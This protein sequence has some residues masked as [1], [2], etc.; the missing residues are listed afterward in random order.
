MEHFLVNMGYALKASYLFVML[1]T[2]L[3]LNFLPFLALHV[4]GGH[5]RKSISFWS[6]S[7]A[8]GIYQFLQLKVIFAWGIVWKDDSWIQLYLGTQNLNSPNPKM[9]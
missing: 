5:E 3:S 1:I 9:R 6:R 7:R 4:L 2:E 8:E